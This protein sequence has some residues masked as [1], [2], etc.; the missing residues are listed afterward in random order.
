MLCAACAAIFF[1]ILV[2]ESSNG[3]IEPVEGNPNRD[4]WK[5]C[6]WNLSEQVSH[7]GNT[8]PIGGGGG[9]R[10]VKPPQ[11]DNKT[12]LNKRELKMNLF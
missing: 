3:N 1:L 10:A 5:N 9:V 4:V 12:T 7:D 6:C 11:V 8:I 2:S